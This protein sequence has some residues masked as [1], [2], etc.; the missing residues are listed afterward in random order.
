MTDLDQI[1]PAFVAALAQLEE[2]KRGRTAKVQT[3]DQGSYSYTYAD[4]ADTLKAVRPIL[5][6]HGL[7]VYQSVGGDASNVTVRTVIIHTS[8]Q[9]ITSDP[10]TLTSG[11]TPQ[12][13][14]S[15]V[16]YARRYSLLAT[17]GMATE[18]D[19][20]RAAA[21]EVPQRRQSSGGVARRTIGR[22][23]ERPT[24]VQTK[25]A[26]AEFAEAGLT[27]RAARL[28]ET[29]RILGRTVESWSDVTRAEATRVIDQLVA[30]R[31]S[32][33]LE[34]EHLPPD[35]P[36]LDEPPPLTAQ[37]AGEDELADRIT[38][39]DGELALQID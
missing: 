21:A 4:L 7:A 16:T 11:R 33:D 36:R 26:M 28:T 30:A 8:G 29:S 19:E 12:A 32:D 9:T 38:D 31:E 2:I 37:E 3:K 34:Q 10:I 27:D 13:T 14:G 17:L 1:A 6:T 20:G 24:E 35:D 25:K 15:A 22:T 23:G 5:A 39:A 18:D